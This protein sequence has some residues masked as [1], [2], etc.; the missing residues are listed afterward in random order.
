[1]AKKT[2]DGLYWTMAP[3]MGS[4]PIPVEIIKTAVAKIE[5]PKKEEKHEFTITLANFSVQE[6]DDEDWESL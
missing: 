2:T 1:M 4:L 5:A 3:I 6:P